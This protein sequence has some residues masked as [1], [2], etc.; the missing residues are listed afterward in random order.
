MLNPEIDSEVDPEDAIS[1]SEGG[2]GMVVHEAVQLRFGWRAFFKAGAPLLVIGGLA[3]AYG[4]L[5]GE[6]KHPSMKLGGALLLAGVAAITTLAGR[7]LLLRRAVEA[8]H[9]RAFVAMERRDVLRVGLALLSVGA[10]I[11]HFAVIEQHFAEYWLYGAF[12]IAVGVF[13]L[14]WAVAV[15][16]APAPVL[17]WVGALVNALTVA[18]YVITRTVGLL[19]GPSASE[20]ELIGFGDLVATVFEGI[21]IV[22]SILLLFRSFGRRRVGSG[23]SEAWIATIAVAVT[24]LTTLALFSTVGG[25]P[26]VTPAG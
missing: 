20:T 24:L 19:I 21:L 1:G 9:P 8:V 7:S 12:F 18:A 14:A 25:R 15:V 6:G 3:T 16:A 10:A 17:Y 11:I 22:G 5:E 2:G 23:G 4:F 26:F 13:E